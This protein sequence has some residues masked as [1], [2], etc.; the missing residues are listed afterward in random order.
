[1]IEAGIDPVEAI[2]MGSLNVAEAFRADR[3]MG[4]IA[5]GRFAD[6]ALLEDLATFKIRKVIFGGEEVVERGKLLVDNQRLSYPSFMTDTVRLAKTYLPDDFRVLTKHKNG[7]VK[8]RVIGGPIWS[9]ANYS[10]RS[11]SLTASF[12]PTRRK[13]WR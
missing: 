10:R 6:M 7:P 11:R 12:R 5:P 1:I 8:V 13:M 2:A 9:P 4:S 3:D